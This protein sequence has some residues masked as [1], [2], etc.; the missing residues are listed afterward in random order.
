MVC[1]SQRLVVAT[2]N[3]DRVEPE[4]R[5][6][7]RDLAKRDVARAVVDDD[8]RQVGESRCTCVQDRF[9]VRPLVQLGVPDQNEN[10][11]LLESACKQRASHAHRD[12]QAMPERARRSFDARHAA[13]VGVR[14]EDAVPLQEPVHLLRR[15]EPV[16]GENGVVGERPVALGEDEAVAAFPAGVL[17]IEPHDLV[18]DLDDVERRVRARIVL[19]VAPRPGNQLYKHSL[20]L[21]DDDIVVQVDPSQKLKALSHPVRFGIALRLA[22]EGGTCACD[23]AEIFAISQ[24][25]VSQHLKVL[26]EAGLVRTRR[27]GTKIY[28][29]LDPDGVRALRAALAPLAA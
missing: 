5:Q 27:E 13:A 17:R 11:W 2:V 16:L 18:K 21:E 26:L 12:R 19:L 9:P 29:S 8:Q 24:P 15:E 22:D 28:Y 14:T 3:R 25:A 20:I 7:R 1:A 23:F 6:L 4:R 10:P